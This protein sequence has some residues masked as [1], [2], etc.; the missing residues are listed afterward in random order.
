MFFCSCGVS[1]GFARCCRLCRKMPARLD[2]E[3]CSEACSNLN[4]RVASSGATSYHQPTVQPAV[5]Q[6][7]QPTS[8]PMHPHVRQPAVQPAPAKLFE[9]YRSSR[10]TQGMTS[11]SGEY[12]TAGISMPRKQPERNDISVPEGLGPTC[13]ECR[14][15]MKETRSRYCSKACEEA[16]RKYHSTSRP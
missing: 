6:M 4:A 5:Q 8:Q 12:A 3:F 16:S 7:M 9:N 1:V 10:G 11:C 2:S 13:Q 15:H 14:R